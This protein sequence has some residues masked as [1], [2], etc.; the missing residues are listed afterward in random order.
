ML[1]LTN[2][3]TL[4]LTSTPPLTNR[5]A[6]LQQVIAWGGAVTT[7]YYTYAAQIAAATTVA[8]LE[9]INWGPALVTL[10]GQDP[11]VTIAG[12]MAIPN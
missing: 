6:Y 9:E 2:L 11:L 4:A 8:Q 5:A 10:K 3:L 1:S 7:T 12:A